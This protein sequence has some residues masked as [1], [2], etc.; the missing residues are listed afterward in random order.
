MFQHATMHTQP[1]EAG[2][3]A[4][5]FLEPVEQSFLS[6]EEGRPVFKD[7]EHVRIL[8]AG[9]A[10]SE[11]VQEVTDQHKARFPQAYAAFKN[12]L[13][14]IEATGTPL[15]HWPAMTPATIKN[16]AAQNIHTVE[17]LAA[18]TDAALQTLGMGARDWRE[19]AK[20]FLATAKDTAAAQ[21]LASENEALRA[22]VDAL[23]AQID[24]LSKALE[25]SKRKAA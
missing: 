24:N 20:A 7:V 10:K 12:N 16:F 17:Q 2:I 22:D 18:V 19:R 1:Q 13:D 3:F 8:I 15:K 23:K 21:K 25:A 5:F 4:E 14:Q 6:R 11:V 9:D